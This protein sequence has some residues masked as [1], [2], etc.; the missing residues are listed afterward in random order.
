MPDPASQPPPAPG[1]EAG[2]AKPAEP[3]PTDPPSI[4]TTILPQRQRDAARHP[5]GDAKA[6]EL[7]ERKGDVVAAEEIAVET[8]EDGDQP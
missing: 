6:S 2:P 7:M 4:A 1:P 5:T 3:G 8:G